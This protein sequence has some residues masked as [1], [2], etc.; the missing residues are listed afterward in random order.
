MSPRS[1]T[2]R[3]SRGPGSSICPIRPPFCSAARQR[4]RSTAVMV[5]TR[6]SS[7][8]GS[9]TRAPTAVPPRSSRGT[10][11]RP[12]PSARSSASERSA[13]W[14]FSPQSTSE[15]CGARIRWDLESLQ[16]HRKSANEPRR[17]C[18][19]QEAKCRVAEGRDLS[20]KSQS[21]HRKRSHRDERRQCIRAGPKSTRGKQQ[22]R[23]R[24]QKREPTKTYDKSRPRAALSCDR[25]Q[26]L[27]DPGDQDAEQKEEG[28]E[29]G[30]VQRRRAESA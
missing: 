6:R 24:E 13:V 20:P 30:H 26:A 1:A 10:A 22:E 12:L 25:R 15:H 3:S 21:G 27:E 19:K 23:P 16:E 7:R 5:C 8:A 17:T 18:Q 9:R 28:A 2:T 14:R 4:S 29:H 11:A